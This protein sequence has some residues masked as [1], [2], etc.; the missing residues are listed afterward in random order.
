MLV[1]IGKQALERLGY[2]MVARTSP[3]EALELFR[4]RPDNFDLVVTDQTMPNMAGDELAKE[5]IRIRPDI[6]VIIC[7]GYSQTIDQGRAADRGIKGFVM[8]PMLINEI[9]VAIRKAL[10]H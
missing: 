1:D 3:I 6:P 4:A 5:L 2:D 8:K 7:T 9:A 10:N